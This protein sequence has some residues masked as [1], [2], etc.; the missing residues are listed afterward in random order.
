MRACRIC[1]KQTD[2]IVRCSRSEAAEL[3]PRA[4]GTHAVCCS[5]AIFGIG[6]QL[7]FTRLLTLSLV[8]RANSWESYGS[9]E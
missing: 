8:R 3:S 6:A 5:V 1:L 7:T 9:T 4:N 2:G